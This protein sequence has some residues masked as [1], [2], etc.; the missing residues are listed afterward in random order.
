MKKIILFFLIINCVLIAQSRWSNTNISSLSQAT[1]VLYVDNKRTDVYTEVG[2][3]N[4]PYK[5]I[6]GAMNAITGNSASNRFCIK[7]AT[8]AYYTENITINKDFV[9]LE[10]YG[11]TLLSGTIT[12]TAPHFRLKNLKTTGVVTGTY[13][14]AFLAE[15]SD[16]SVS[17]GKWTVSCSVTGAYVQISGGTTLWTSDIDLSGVTGVVS[18]QSGYFEGTHTFTNCYM[19]IIGFENYNGVI[20]LE[21]GTEIH[22]GASLCIGTTVNLKTGATAY[23]D[24]TSASGITLNNTGG[25]L[26]LTTE[27]NNINYD[28]TTS[29]MTA[30]NV[31]TA[32]DELKT[33]LIG[34]GGNFELI[35]M[36]GRSILYGV[37]GTTY[38]PF[39]SYG[40]TIF[41]VD[42]INGTDDLEHGYGTGTSAFATV[43]YA[44][45][46]IPAL[47]YGNV[48][49]YLASGQA[50]AENVVIQGK[51]VIGDYNI[52]I[53]GTTTTLT[54]GT[55]TSGSVAGTGSTLGTL[56]NNA[57]TWTASAYTYQY[58]KITSGALSGQIRMIKDNTASTLSILGGWA[59]APVSDVTFDILSGSSTNNPR[60]NS[61]TMKG[62]QNVI[63]EFVAFISDTS[64]VSIWGEANSQS[65]IRYCFL[66]GC[67]L[68]TACKMAIISCNSIACTTGNGGMT[69]DCYS[70]LNTWF[71]TSRIDIKSCW[72]RTLF[73]TQV[74]IINFDHC[75][76]G[77]IFGNT[78][79]TGNTS[80]AYAP[81]GVWIGNNSLVDFEGTNY[82]IIEYLTVGVYATHG[83]VGSPIAY[84]TYTSCTTNNSANT[85]SYGY[86]D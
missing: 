73:T 34:A 75:S 49:I 11:E 19:E 69:V 66:P 17:T 29:G 38:R 23:I 50:F 65:T 52:Y 68:T 13:T 70:G 58:V 32:I 5:T 7:I 30:S 27:S 82:N 43:Q 21:T 25:T 59:T 63:V 15:I 46:Q 79:I 16:C 80:G 57:S 10:G 77:F 67:V 84:N 64:G 12:L 28:N 39:A 81:R 54:T 6:M 86:I 44:V 41:Y 74:G 61:L 31:K 48:Y 76:A 1:N 72:F 36:T 71:R 18:C 60:L 20:N 55:T 2:T 45:D 35:T 9:T 53:S 3:Y 26:V 56:V 47:C 37:E 42:G 14:S 85:T 22:I 33:E 4:L 83:G 40:T 8:G 78:E 24:A 62:Q 51:Q